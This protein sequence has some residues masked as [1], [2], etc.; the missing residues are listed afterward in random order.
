MC[1]CLVC[2][3]AREFEA[4]AQA[5]PVEHQGFLREVFESWMQANDDLAY[6][7]AVIDGSWPSADEVIAHRR[8]ARQA[9]QQRQ[10]QAAA[11]AQT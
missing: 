7:H 9:K 1:D 8:Q 6:A 4:V 10:E 2:S 11:A 3:K 5:C